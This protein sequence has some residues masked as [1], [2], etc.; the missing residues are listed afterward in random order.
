MR[1]G[2]S[3][4]NAGDAAEMRHALD[5]QEGVGYNLTSVDGSLK[6]TVAG[7]LEQSHEENVPAQGQAKKQS[8][9]FHETNGHE[10][11]PVGA[12]AAAHEG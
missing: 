9:W 3:W 4:A 1:E 8:A 11:R 10:G 6:R 2:M 12:Q 5:M 7:G